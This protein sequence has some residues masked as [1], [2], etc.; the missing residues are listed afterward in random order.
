[1]A[2]NNLG[3]TYECVG[4]LKEAMCSYQRALTLNGNLT[5]ARVNLASLMARTNQCNGGKSPGLWQSDS[6]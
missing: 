1:M 2:H 6:G 4:K 3:W 5:L